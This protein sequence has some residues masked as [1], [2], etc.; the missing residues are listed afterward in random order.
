M[1]PLTDHNKYRILEDIITPLG[2]LP[3]EKQLILKRNLVRDHVELLT[4]KKCKHS[5]ILPITPSVRSVLFTSLLLVSTKSFS[6]DLLIL[7]NSLFLIIIET[8]MN[9]TFIW[10]KMEIPKHSDFLLVILAIIQCL[11]LALLTCVM[12]NLNIN[13][14]CR[15][16]F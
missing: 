8:K 12:L 6:I 3:Y 11:L 5:R 16:E 2:R 1:E 14:C 15:Y 4:K 10:G 9:S 7:L 13:K